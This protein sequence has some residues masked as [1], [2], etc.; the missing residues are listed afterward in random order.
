M[1][2]TELQ[3]TREIDRKLRSIVRE[4]PILRLRG[5]CIADQRIEAW[6]IWTT[7]SKLELILQCRYE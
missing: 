2:K 3:L 4:H 6:K 5:K 7:Y 1:K